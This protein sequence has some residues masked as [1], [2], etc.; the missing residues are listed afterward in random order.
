MSEKRFDSEISIKPRH[1]VYLETRIHR[2]LGRSCGRARLDEIV[3]RDRR[4]EAISSRAAREHR[5]YSQSRVW[6]GSDDQLNRIERDQQIVLESLALFI[7]YQFLIT[8]HSP[9]AELAAS[10]P[11]ATN[12]F[13]PSSIR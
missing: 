12:G 11:P 5:R 9:D 1:H 3:D 8:R 10:R 6:I 4:A 13:K 2:T 7:R